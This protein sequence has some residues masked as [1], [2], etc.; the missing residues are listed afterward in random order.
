MIVNVD[1]SFI[2]SSQSPGQLLADTETDSFDEIEEIEETR[3]A[4]QSISTIDTLNFP[5][6]EVEISLVF[7][8]D[9]ELHDNRPTG[10]SCT[11]A[12]QSARGHVIKQNSFDSVYL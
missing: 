9:Q 7:P 2:S 3:A 11:V 6:T 1:N 8:Q 12:E 10:V 5:E 4:S